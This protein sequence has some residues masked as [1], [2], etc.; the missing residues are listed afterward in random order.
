MASGGTTVPARAP[1]PAP[2]QSLAA[3][4]FERLLAFGA[5]ILLGFVAGT[6]Q[7]Y[8]AA[9]FYTLAYTLTTL[10]AFGVLLLAGGAGGEADDLAYYRGMH[11]RDP[12]LS[13]LLMVAMF[14]FA[15]IPLTVGFL[16]KLQ[17]FAALWTAGQAALVVFAAAVSVIGLFY[18]LRVVKILYFDAPGDLPIPAQQGGVRLALALNA[19]AVIALGVFPQSLIALCARILP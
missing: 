6:E 19:A 7:G 9:L 12:L 4:S 17:I 13:L 3:D 8:E 18:Y 11:A 14:S 10:G 15:G 5:I 1:Q 16:A 2:P